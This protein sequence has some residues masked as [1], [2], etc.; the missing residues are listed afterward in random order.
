MY[1]T[2]MGIYKSLISADLSVITIES[3]TLISKTAENI[4]EHQNVMMTDETLTIMD[5]ILRISNILYENTSGDILP[6]DDGIYD[7]LIVLYKKYRPNYVIGAIRVN[8]NESAQNEVDE[9]KVMCNGALRSDIENGF[10][11]KDILAQYMRKDN[12]LRTMCTRVQGPITKRLIN[13]QHSYP[14]LVGT[15]D[16]CKFVLNNDAIEK[17][18]FDKD[19]VQVFER[20]YMFKL[21]T[22]GILDMQSYY[23]LLGELKYDG[24]SVEADICGDRITGA[25]SRGD[26]GEDLA[27]DLTPIFGGYQ[28]PSA[29]EV[30]KDIT[31]GMKFE[32]VI[33]KSD[34]RRLSEL[35][36]KSYKNCRNA[37]IGLLSASDS[38]LYRDFITLIPL[39]TSL[40]MDRLDEI[41]F[42]NKY[43]TS[44]QYNRFVVMEGNYMQ[45]LYQV[46]QFTESVE[47]IRASLPYLVDGVVVSFVDKNIIQRLGRENSV[48]KYQ[49][50]IKFNPK[51]IRTL[52]LGYTFE[53]GKTGDINPMA[54]FKACDFI[55]TIHDKQT[56]HSYKRFMELGLRY[57]D[58]IDVEYM[59]E[60][61]VYVTKPDTEHNRNNTNPLIEFPAA[62]PSCGAPIE[63]S[64]TGKSARCNNQDCHEKKIM[65]MVS[66]IS[67]LGIVNFAEETIRLLNIKSFDDLFNITAETASI[68]G[69]NDSVYLIQQLNDL[70][71]NPMPDYKVMASIG[72]NNIGERLWKSIFKILDIDDI[73][74][75]PSDTLYNALVGI[76]GIGSATANNILETRILYHDDI[77]RTLSEVKLIKTD[78]GLSDLPQVPITGFR[79]KEFEQLLID[80]GFE[81]ND[82]L[83][84]TKKSYALV[85]A[86][87]NGNS[88]KLTKAKSYGIPIYTKQEFMDV[89]NIKL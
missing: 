17:G 51:K 81:C 83:G 76:D 63:I 77:A 72:F 52:F 46:K 41:N 85:V 70:R 66:A 27:T 78:R 80:N 19:S 11:T 31:F 53:V 87:K 13:T 33:T 64:D 28:F 44:G 25:R 73:I 69:P 55:G 2:L 20:D 6:L 82:S 26:T 74:N 39:S 35:R 9:I 15:L 5:L 22:M 34:L 24:V 49:M 16:K 86:D 54:H 3:S 47:C 1:N 36:G 10:Y 79:D 14:E 38:Y 8:F 37:I 71:L 57:G 68:L 32:A 60:V 67:T 45:L 88:S 40:D 62:C 43:Y 18:V 42:L 75:S 61:I 58:E 89:H 29:G 12:R 4:L 23:I 21:L 56:V 30:P 7:Q 48:N 84:L 65:R 59:N 50:A